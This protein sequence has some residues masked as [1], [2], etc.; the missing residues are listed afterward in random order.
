M[1]GNMAAKGTQRKE[2]VSSYIP[3]TDLAGET[4][5]IWVRAGSL[6]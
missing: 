6:P 2:E 5:C 1:I 3:R 4:P